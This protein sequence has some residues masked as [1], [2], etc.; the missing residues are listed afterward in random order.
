[1]ELVCGLKFFLY[2]IAGIY[3]LSNWE[4]TKGIWVWLMCWL[5]IT[6]IM[7]MIIIVFSNYA[8]LYTSKSCAL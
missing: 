1:M 8:V 6:M 3:T 5:K 2:F 7:R 4:V